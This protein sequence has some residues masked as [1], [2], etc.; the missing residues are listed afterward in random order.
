MRFLPPPVFNK[1][2]LIS[3]VDITLLLKI[4]SIAP[5]LVFSKNLFYQGHLRALEVHFLTI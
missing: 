1:I 5:I 4:Q 2:Q 3:E